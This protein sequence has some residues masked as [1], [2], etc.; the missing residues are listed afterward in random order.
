MK[1][2]LYDKAQDATSIPEKIITG[3]LADK[4][5]G[6]SFPVVLA[7]S[8][9][10]D[11]IGLG[12]TDATEITITSGSNVR[13]IPYTSKGLYSV[14]EF[15]SSSFTVTTNGTY[16]GRMAF[17]EGLSIGLSPQRE[18]GRFTTNQNRTTASGNPIP[19]A[20][21]YSGKSFGFDVRYK[22]GS[23][24]FDQLDKAYDTQISKGFPVFV[25]FEK[26]NLYPYLLFYG[27][28]ENE[29]MVFQ[30]SVNSYKYSKRFQLY[31]AF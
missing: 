3:A 2:L 26:S 29:N 13:T 6:S 18:P 17:G 11:V 22:L 21:G 30:S 25:D 15:T 14:Q 8:E 16:L 12:Y 28:F 5:V 24:F 23:S 4:Y 1:I 27:K 10:I 20:G 9:K 7:Q 19:G 31:E